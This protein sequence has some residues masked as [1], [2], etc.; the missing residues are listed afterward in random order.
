[1]EIIEGVI[2]DYY[3]V[4]VE[5]L[6]AKKRSRDIAHPRQVAMYLCR[7]MTDT[8]LPQIGAFFG[9]RDHTTVI[10]ACD[11]IGHDRE[12]NV[13]VAREIKEIEERLKSM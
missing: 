4:T 2:A 13:S 7:E 3:K 11:K 5:N 6:K 9:G 1:M 10:H 12:T 8:S